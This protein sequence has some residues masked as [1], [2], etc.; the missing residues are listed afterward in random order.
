MKLSKLSAGVAASILVVTVGSTA[1]AQLSDG[2]PTHRHKTKRQPPVNH[3]PHGSGE[4]GDSVVDLTLAQIA[5]FEAGREE[6]ESVETAE[7]GL[8]PIFNNN[9]CASCHSLQTSGGAS[10]TTVTRF[11]RVTNGHFDPLDALGGSLLQKFAINDEL[12]ERVPAEANV[13]AQ[14]LT[15][16]L[17]GAG[18]TEAIPDEAIVANAQRRQPD[19]IAGRA[20]MIIDVAT[21]Q[22]HV[23]R[24]G[25]KAQH[26]SLLSFAADAYLNEMGI[27]T[28][29]F[30]TENAPNGNTAL[31]AKYDKLTDP[32]DQVDPATG[33]SDI[34]MAAD[35]MRFLAPPP[36]LQTT[37]SI[38]QGAHIFDKLQCDACHV[39][40]MLTGASPISAL[41]QKRVALFS[42]LLLHDM[43]A[44]GDGIEQGAARGRE[45]K[46]APLWGLR[47]R[48]PYLHDGRAATIPEAIRGHDGEAAAARNRFEA[49]SSEDQAHLVDFLNS[50]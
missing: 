42:D 16:P 10:D 37:G 41:A 40:A 23:G 1:V 36:T 48:R 34:D 29:F 39:P 21:G 35:F 9:S 3:P 12:L 14:R 43:G 44:L 15:T 25:W 38:A 5:A 26:S 47:A 46:T 19:G 7:G 6:F 8:G 49:L 20:A 50:I 4:F 31:L 2:S 45:M 30:P 17:F 11:G 27:T 24:F 18:L 13:V 33:K 32:E 28:R 22:T